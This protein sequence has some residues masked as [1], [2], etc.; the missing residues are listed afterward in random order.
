MLRH[1]VVAG[2]IPFLPAIGL[3]DGHCV[4]LVDVKQKKN[5][6]TYRLLEKAFIEA[7][8]QADSPATI[9]P[10]SNSKQ[11]QSKRVKTQMAKDKARTLREKREKKAMKSL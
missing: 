6:M 10:L 11:F 8:K 4:L 7:K 5:V 1:K 9:I 2:D 3:H